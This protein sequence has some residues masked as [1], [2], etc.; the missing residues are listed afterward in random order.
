MPHSHSDA[1]DVARE[2]LTAFLPDAVALMIDL[3]MTAEN[4]QVQLK[5]LETIMD[6][7][8]LSKPVHVDITVDER[9]RGRVR[10]EANDVLARLERNRGAIEAPALS[11]EAIVLHEGIVEDLP[12]AAPDQYGGVVEATSRDA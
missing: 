7:A 2:R 8:G 12:V 9:E 4:E 1:L 3:A 5:A 6:R 10:D 11:L